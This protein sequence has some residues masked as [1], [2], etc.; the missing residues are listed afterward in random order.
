MPP[1]RS[2]SEVLSA[3]KRCTT[4][5]IFRQFPNLKKKPY[6]GNRFWAKGDCVDAV[7]MDAEMVRK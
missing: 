3:V 1:K 4:I 6:W 2:I 7:G 5:R